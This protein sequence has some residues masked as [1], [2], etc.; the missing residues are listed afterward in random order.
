MTDERKASSGAKLSK[1]AVEAI[2]APAYTAL[3]DAIRTAGG[4]GPD[5]VLAAMMVALS[6]ICGVALPGRQ[7]ALLE[8]MFEEI[9]MRLTDPAEG[10]TLQ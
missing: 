3:A 1:E 7:D 8:W 10:R 5:L 4:E 2:A 9:A 6:T